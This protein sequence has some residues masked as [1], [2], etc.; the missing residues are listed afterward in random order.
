MTDLLLLEH[1]YL[2]KVDQSLPFITLFARRQT[3]FDTVQGLR[4]LKSLE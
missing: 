3:K 2:V 1:P 4:Q